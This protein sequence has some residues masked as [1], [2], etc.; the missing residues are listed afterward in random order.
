VVTTFAPPE[1]ET[2]EQ[3]VSRCKTWGY[4]IGG[5]SQ[6]L[7]ERRLVQIATMGAVTP[8][9]CAGLFNRLGRWMKQQKRTDGR[10]ARRETV[11]ASA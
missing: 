8:A 5:H 2:S 10:G 11:T 3:L 7:A 9:E 6:Y 4:S 1:P